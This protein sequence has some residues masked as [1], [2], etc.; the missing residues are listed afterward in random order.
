ME[1]GRGRRPAWSSP[2]S[3][4]S[5]FKLQVSSILLPSLFLLFTLALLPA[6]VSNSRMLGNCG[7][8]GHAESSPARMIG[9][10]PP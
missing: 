1:E 7:R 5:V 3:S 4:S 2:A 10:D 9:L 6:C 8:A